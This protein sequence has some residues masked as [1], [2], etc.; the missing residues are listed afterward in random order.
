M[1]YGKIPVFL[2]NKSHVHIS[3]LQIGG[4]Y[5]LKNNRLSLSVEHLSSSALIDDKQFERWD[6]ESKIL[7]ETR[8]VI[9][10]FF[11]ECS[12]VKPVFSFQQSLT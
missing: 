6:T 2:P 4:A 8:C 5:R 11:L 7:Q 9:S 1:Q 3:L 12:Q 10:T